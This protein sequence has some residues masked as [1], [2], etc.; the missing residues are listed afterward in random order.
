[1]VDLQGH[2]NDA[3]LSSLPFPL[4]FVLREAVLE[5]GDDERR[6]RGIIQ[7]FTTG[8]QYAALICA[9][10][11]AREDY[12]DEH[13]SWSLERLKR[14]LISDLFNFVKTAVDSLARRGA[15]PFVAEMGEF[16][17]ALERTRV[18]VPV[19][20]D[21]RPREQSLLLRKALVELRNT[22]GHKLYQADWGQLSAQ[23]LPHLMRFLDALSWCAEYP[24][25]RVLGEESAARL[26]GAEPRFATEPL[27][28][29]ARAELAGSRAEAETSGL[30]LAN[31]ELTRFLNLY[32]LM[33]VAPC[34]ECRAEP[35]R[36]L[37]EEPFLFNGDEGK[38]LVYLG[39]RHS[40]NTERVRD[41]V[42]LIYHSKKTLPPVIR[43]GQVTPHELCQRAERQAA[44]LLSQNINARRYLTQVY[45]AR[46][47]MDEALRSFTRGAHTG[48]L[49]LGEAGIGKTSLLCRKVEEWGGGPGPAGGQTAGDVTLFYQGRGLFAQGPLEE[50][51]MGDLY[52]EGGFQDLLSRL[53]PTGRKLVLVI[54]AVNED[55]NPART[56]QAVCQFVA[57]H[58]RLSAGG[59][60]R[61]PLK[62]VFSFRTA[63]YHKTLNAL[64]YA[65]DGDE[66]RELF[67]HDVFMTREVERQG[68]RQRTHRFELE[69]MSVEEAAVAYETYRSFEGIADEETGGRRRFSPTTPF[70]SLN[71]RTRQLLTHP[72]H[73]RMALE[74]FDGRALPP[75]LWAGALLE[76]FCKTKIYGRGERG[77]ELFADRADFVDELVRLMRERKAATAERADLL[78]EPRLARAVGETQLRLS[79]YLQLIDEGVLMEGAETESSGLRA[80]KRF[81]VR[82]A[83]DPMFEYLL[84]D[85][86]L[87]EESLRVEDVAGLKDAKLASL[88][89]E[90]RQF[91]PLRGAVRFLLLEEL[92]RGLFSGFVK[93]ARACDTEWAEVFV[94][95]LDSWFQTIRDT[96][97]EQQFWDVLGAMSLAAGEAGYLVLDALC[98]KNF[99]RSRFEVAYRL[100]CLIDAGYAD[101][102]DTVGLAAYRFM[103]A[104]VLIHW[105]RH[106]S[107][108]D[109]MLQ[110]MRELEGQQP[111]PQLF[112]LLTNC[113]AY[114]GMAQ[115]S[116]GFTDRAIEILEGAW[117]DVE[118]K[119]AGGEDEQNLS[120]LVGSMLVNAYRSAGK[121]DLAE[122]VELAVTEGMSAD[123]ETMLGMA[124]GRAGL[125]RDREQYEES[126]KVLREALQGVAEDELPPET[127]SK[128]YNA[129]GISLARAARHD[130]ARQ[131]YEK[132]AKVAE[133]NK[134]WGTLS[135][136][137]ADLGFLGVQLFSKAIV[138][139]RNAH[140]GR[141]DEAAL[142]WHLLDEADANLR[143]SLKICEEFPNAPLE[144]EIFRN[145]AAVAA[146]RNDIH[147]N[148]EYKRK[149]IGHYLKLRNYQS[150][151]AA[152]DDMLETFN[153]VG[154]YAKAAEIAHE[155]LDLAAG[156]GQTETE[157]RIRRALI[158]AYTTAGKWKEALDV[159]E[160]W[161]ERTPLY[162]DA[163]DLGVVLVCFGDV[164][165][166]ELGDPE[167]ATRY[168]REGV[169]AFERSDA[170]GVAANP[171]LRL[172]K[173]LAGAGRT[174][175]ALGEVER[176]KEDA[177]S[178][179]DAGQRA[180][181]L[182]G[183]GQLLCRLGRHAE[184]RGVFLS[185]IEA[186]ED[187]GDADFAEHVRDN[188]LILAEV[189]AGRAAV[190]D[191]RTAESGEE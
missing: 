145:F 33:F 91:Q 184:A 109:L 105:G 98:L 76:E 178:L 92:T 71:Q 115:A 7:T 48:F 149:E 134:L 113:K 15:S 124:M 29:G 77:Q 97:G 68:Q 47:E 160:G 69:A 51:V 159:F 73:L 24:L 14:P 49:L 38:F 96:E 80:R 11:Y 28:P 147:L 46:A 56:L 8:I 165:E 104:K 31:R 93:H 138:E 126:V 155:A 108:R 25:L 60:P 169:E 9:S 20:I 100:A 57:R 75:S 117:R 74:T 182:A 129:L 39:V 85:L 183:A 3:R 67:P 55:E 64:G 143:R 26:V 99:E 154:D 142:P 127:L 157:G 116:L 158:K 185:S 131:A 84:A 54:D 16:A 42:D 176:V 59:E 172:A 135:F 90:S 34:A 94:S 170:P 40:R 1:M 112:R 175:E 86:I 53:R 137:L 173:L 32:P 148:E 13:L 95:C 50:R 12:L 188:W 164:C 45:Q 4:A 6:V 41:R 163:R 128:A 66:A 63:F 19:M 44:Q 106:E 121:T 87:R 123:P 5:A 132:S 171:R 81:L 89:E 61:A 186:A 35:L 177:P 122:R 22:L 141:I 168:Y 191:D 150:V 88:L 52:L 2:A 111:T 10:Q 79:P 146:A 130:E 107:G 156:H 110:V 161:D 119:R 27:P 125:L 30:M 144:A 167:K 174:A 190:S 162:A 72:W 166:T 82:F 78:L 139:S 140:P 152:Y 17:A 58:A 101:K 187:A 181:I 70:D 23:Y 62:V 37:T 189:M 180:R 65:G 120:T 133:G 153:H 114:L 179:E 36:G 102:L 151:F 103:Q 21:G 43:V 118:A 18:S 83:F 136:A